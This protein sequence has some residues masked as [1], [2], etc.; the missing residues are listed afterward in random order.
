MARP[1]ANVIRAFAVAVDN[2]VVAEA[3]FRPNPI[4]AI[5]DGDYRPKQYQESGLFQA[6]GEMGI[7]SAGIEHQFSQLVKGRPVLIHDGTSGLS[8]VLMW[9]RLE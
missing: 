8:N 9:P 4:V 2:F 7:A 6:R 5:P 1:V 3:I